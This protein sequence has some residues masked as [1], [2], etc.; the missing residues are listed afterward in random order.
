M[1]TTFGIIHHFKGATMDQYRNTLAAVHPDGGKGL[2]PGQTYHAAGPADDGVVIVA[3]WDSEAS[4]VQFR[5]GSL[6]PGLATVENGLP[7]PPEE[8]TFQVQNTLSA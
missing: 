4:W 1:A 7:G 6:M 3:L 2:P 5:D 8:T